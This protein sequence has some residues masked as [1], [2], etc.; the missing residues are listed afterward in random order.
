VV[1][2]G[3]WLAVDFFARGFYGCTAVA[4]LPLHQLGFLVCS[5]VTISS[6]CGKVEGGMVTIFTSKTCFTFGL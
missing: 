2:F 6:K 1:G 5:V 4:H 3:I